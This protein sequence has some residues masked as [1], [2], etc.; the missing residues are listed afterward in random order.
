M[1]TTLLLLSKDFVVVD[2]SSSLLLGVSSLYLDQKS[3]YFSHIFE[4][5][6]SSNSISSVFGPESLIV[7]N[8]PFFTILVSGSLMLISLMYRLL[9]TIHLATIRTSVNRNKLPGET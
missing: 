6:S 5:D 3:M 8:F 1:D 9:D 2:I 7:I 4:M